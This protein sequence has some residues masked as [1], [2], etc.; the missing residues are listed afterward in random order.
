MTDCNAEPY[1][2]HLETRWLLVTL[3]VSGVVAFLLGISPPRLTAPGF[4][5]PWINAV[6]SG[7]PTIDNIA[8]WTSKPWWAKFLLS[9]QWTLAPVYILIW[10]IAFSPWS[11]KVKASVI[12]NKKMLTG[13]QR[14][15]FLGVTV[16]LI[17]Y[18]LSDLGLLGLPTLF[19]GEF[20]YPPSEA[21]PIIRP[22]YSSWT[23]LSMYAWLSVNC[24]CAMLWMLI[25]MLFNSRGI[26]GRNNKE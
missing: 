16:F 18:F 26:Y 4:L 1:G 23:Y 11:S 10:I 25:F 22:I 9:L 14:L 15:L 5:E 20:T 7:V 19:N 3:I 6:A 24:E 2:F 13:K 8:M 17:V 21:V 12:R